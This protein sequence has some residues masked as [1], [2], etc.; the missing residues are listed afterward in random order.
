[1]QREVEVWPPIWFSEPPAR[2]GYVA[3]TAL[4]SAPKIKDA[5]NNALVN[6]RVR[7]ASIIE[8]YIES[9]TRM[10]RREVN[11]SSKRSRSEGTFETICKQVTESTVHATQEAKQAFRYNSKT[12]AY[13]YAVLMYMPLTFLE[14]EFKQV[15][16]DE[17]RE[18]EEPDQ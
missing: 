7:L 10:T 1:M 15:Q 9:E 6:A 17:K 8:V 13:E 5:Y 14:R 2:A 4:G 16:R 18:T 11:S 12:K 3:V